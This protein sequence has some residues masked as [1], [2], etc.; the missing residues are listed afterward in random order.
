MRAWIYD[1]FLLPL[2]TGWYKEVIARVPNDSRLLDVGIGTAGALIGNADLVRAK[3]ITVVGVDID[4]DYIN[5]AEQYIE[6]H[7]LDDRVKVLHQSIYD[8]HD[9]PY[10]AI[11][12]AASFMLMPDPAAILQHCYGILAPGGRIYFTQTFQ[13]SKSKMA[14]AVKPMLKKVTTIDF[15]SVTYE[16]DFVSLVAGAGLQIDEMTTMSRS[17]SRTYRIVVGRPEGSS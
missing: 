9:G 3:N 12:F 6:E 10:D 15:G 1:Q 16:E 14:E 7:E 13:E 11:Y 17:R 8:H 5:R 2:T 4:A